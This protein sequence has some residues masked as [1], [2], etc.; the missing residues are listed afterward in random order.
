MISLKKYAFG[1]LCGLTAIAAHGAPLPPLDSTSIRVEYVLESSN[2]EKAESILSRQVL[3]SV[4]QSADSVYFGNVSDCTCECD[5]G[6][7]FFYFANGKKVKPVFFSSA[8][9]DRLC[10]TVGNNQ[11]LIWR[12]KDSSKLKAVIDSVMEK[13]LKK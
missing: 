9:M 8:L 12:L 2:N 5:G 11:A 4:I 3:E 13:N 6:D 10:S 7:L 1:V